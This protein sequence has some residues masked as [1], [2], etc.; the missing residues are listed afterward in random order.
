MNRIISE[1]KGLTAQKQKTNLSNDIKK[2]FLWWQLF[3]SKFNGVEL[4][5]P[6]DIAFQVAGDACPMGLGSWNITCGEYF[7]RKFPFN[8]QDPSLPI[9]C[10]EFLCVILAVKC[11][12]QSWSGKRVL[13]YCDNDAV[14]DVVSYMKPK[15]DKMQR[16]LREFLYWVC[17]FNFSPVVSKIGTKENSVADFISRN[18]SSSDFESF[19]LKQNLP[20]M[21]EILV[22]DTDFDLVAEW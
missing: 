5:V 21:T 12:G 19:C 10:K 13:I 8:L 2:D 15:D 1:I 18:F 11:W 22:N 4:M 20:K 14:C 16:L 9:H 17:L 3:I 7:S 6:E